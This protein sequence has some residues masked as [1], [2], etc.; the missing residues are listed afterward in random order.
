MDA[1]SE[2]LDVRSRDAD[3]LARMVAVSLAAHVAIIAALTIMP[4]FSTG[5]DDRVRVMTISLAGAEGPQQGRN[6]MD[7]RKVETVVPEGKKPADTPPMATKPEMIEPVKKAPAPPKANAKPD[8]AKPL[9][10]LQGRTP[11]Q[12]AEVNKGTARIETNS[13]AQTQTPGLATGGGGTGGM[14]TDY[15]D[16]C[17]PEYLVQ[18]QTLIKRNWQPRQGQVG[19]STVKF[20]IQRDGT[21]TDVSIKEGSN[22]LLNLASQRALILTRSV[23]PLPAGFPPQQMTV[24]LVFEYQR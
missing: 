17:C 16:F 2:V 4:R 3:S 21:I 22:Q 19:Q 20:T 13:T 11:S 5:Q 15:A 23:P 12:G 8:P 9:P 7:A 6:P 1:V 10:Q 18:V 24:Y 14:Y